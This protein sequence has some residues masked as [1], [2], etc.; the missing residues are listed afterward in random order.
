MKL[1]F[2]LYL[3]L[4][5]VQHSVPGQLTISTLAT[6]IRLL[7]SINDRHSWLPQTTL[8]T[9]KHQENHRHS[10][11]RLL[12]RT[13]TPRFLIWKV[14]GTFD[15]M[16]EPYK[17][18]PTNHQLTF[19]APQPGPAAAN[20]RYPRRANGPLTSCTPLRRRPVAGLA[21]L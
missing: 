13:S 17:P 19:W 20:A 14:A 4:P 3:L 8:Y 6:S 11:R 15:P 7:L 5:L 21:P 16:L 2:C 1:D 9:K 10:P 12:G 18:P